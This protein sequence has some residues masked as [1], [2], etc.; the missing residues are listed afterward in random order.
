M[1][2]RQDRLKILAVWSVA[3]F[4]MTA[5]AEPS[6][7]AVGGP[8]PSASGLELYASVG[9]AAEAGDIHGSGGASVGGFGL[10]S[11]FPSRRAGWGAF[12]GLDVAWF[13]PTQPRLGTQFPFDPTKGL[14]MNR[15]TLS[16]N[17]CG[18]ME[19]PVNV[20]VGVGYAIYVLSQNSDYEQS[21]G[22]PVYSL[23]LNAPVSP[24]WMVGASTDWSRI[25]QKIAAAGSA[26]EIWRSTAT[27]GYL[28]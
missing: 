17:V 25:A 8:P 22:A 24:H 12:L 21:Y 14:R 27:V 18:G 20:C 16:L 9:Y 3:L 23:S 6:E 7:V 19:R 5:T 11:W 26:D 2:F 1:G 15:N 28:F 13:Q 4:S 10:N